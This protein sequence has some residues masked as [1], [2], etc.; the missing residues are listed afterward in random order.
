MKKRGRKEQCEYLDDDWWA[1]TAPIL[2]SGSALSDKLRS[3]SLCA[4][5][6]LQL[7]RL[8]TQHQTKSACFMYY[9]RL[10]VAMVF[11]V[12]PLSGVGL[13]ELPTCLQNY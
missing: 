5:F 3:G 4:F 7:S 11:P 8:L 13:L 12:T 10:T 1:S 6:V 2:A 9:L